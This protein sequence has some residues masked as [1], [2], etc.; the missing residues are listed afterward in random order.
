L[1]ISGRRERKQDPL[2]EAGEI[3]RML[4]R[5]REAGPRLFPNQ[6]KQLI[7]MLRAAR[8]IERRP[9]TETLRGR[10][11]QFDRQKLLQAAALAG[12]VLER[13][14]SGRVSFGHFVDHYLRVPGL[15]RDVAKRLASGEINLSEAFELAKL[16]PRRLAC[17]TV[18]AAA[19]RTAVLEQHLSKKGATAALRARVAEILDPGD[20]DEQLSLQHT[21]EES[22]RVA[23]EIDEY[24]ELEDFDA[25]HLFFEE[26]KRILIALKELEPEDVTPALLD[27]FLSVNDRLWGVIGKMQKRRTERIRPRKKML[28]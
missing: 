11:G 9:A 15:P 7:K 6:E 28:I 19:R 1:S 17:D 3:R 8:H 10:P 21:D 22:L 26:L 5:F 24:A 13:E 14:T 18:E 16:N 12:Q 2:A 20:T 4:D 27:E 23:A 25:R